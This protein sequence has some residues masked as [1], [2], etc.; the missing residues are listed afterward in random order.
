MTVFKLY[1]GTFLLLPDASGCWDLFGLFPC[2]RKR[3]ITFP[4]SRHD[5]LPVSKSLLGICFMLPFISFFISF[6]SKAPFLIQC[7]NKYELYLHLWVLS[8]STL[9]RR[10]DQQRSVDKT[11]KTSVNHTHS[12]YMNNR[13]LKNVYLLPANTTWG[14]YWFLSGICSVLLLW[15][16]CV[17]SHWELRPQCI[18]H[19]ARIDLKNQLCKT[20]CISRRATPERC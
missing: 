14:F 10:G 7:S 8:R 2:R 9:W 12:R 13:H 6:L 17:S 20:Y 11:I 15:P 16:K 5:P 1:F 3:H 18:S 4:Y 19:K